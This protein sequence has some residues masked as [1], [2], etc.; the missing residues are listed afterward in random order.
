MQDCSIVQFSEITVNGNTPLMKKAKCKHV[1]G[2]NNCSLCCES[3]TPER[4]K[5][6]SKA[7]L[8]TITKK[9]KKKEYLMS[10]I[11]Q[12][13]QAASRMNALFI[14][15]HKMSTVPGGKSAD[16][17]YT[18]RL[19]LN[20]CSSDNQTKQKNKKKHLMSSNSQQGQVTSSMSILF[21]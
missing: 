11:C 21:N 19:Q 10:S 3:E 16:R 9:K 2:R 17:H 13:G 7:G 18:C 15:K 1:K 4:K 20:N 8:Q 5:R 12:Q 6:N 14:Q